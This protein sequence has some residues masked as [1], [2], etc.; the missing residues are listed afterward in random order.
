M[1]YRYLNVD[2]S[3]ITQDKMQDDSKLYNSKSTFHKDTKIYSM[4]IMQVWN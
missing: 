1:S 3:K 2:N 4:A